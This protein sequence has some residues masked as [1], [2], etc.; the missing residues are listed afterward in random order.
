MS[1]YCIQC[2]VGELNKNLFLIMIEIRKKIDDVNTNVML[3]DALSGSV[4]CCKWFLK[5]YDF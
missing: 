1:E 5:A 4:M 2:C 3:I